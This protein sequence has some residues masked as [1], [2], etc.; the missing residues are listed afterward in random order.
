M[1]QVADTN[2]DTSIISPSDDD[3]DELCKGSTSKMSQAKSKATAASRKNRGD[4][5]APSR[6]PQTK[7]EERIMLHRA[8]CILEERD[9]LPGRH[10]R[11]AHEYLVLAPVCVERCD[12]LLRR[13]LQDWQNARND[14][15]SWRTAKYPREGCACYPHFAK[16]MRKGKRSVL[17][18]NVYGINLSLSGDVRIYGATWEVKA[19]D[20]RLRQQED[21]EIYKSL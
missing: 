8:M 10:G 6:A 7:P 9:K 19:C 3:E 2:S 1:S 4:G 15:W 14:C 21:I 5:I 17:P 11:S 16:R 20:D 13:L 18:P 12:L